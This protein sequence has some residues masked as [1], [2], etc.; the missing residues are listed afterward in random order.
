MNVLIKLSWGKKI[1]QNFWFLVTNRPILVTVVLLMIFAI[2]TLASAATPPSPSSSTASP[3]LPNTFEAGFEQT[4]KSV[5]NNKT[6]S[7]KGTIAYLYPGHI[8]FE[9][10]EPTSEKS[11]FISN[12]NQSWYYTPP[13]DEAEKGEV[14][15]QKSNR[16]FVVKFFDSIRS[17]LKNNSMYT[18]KKD[19][20]QQTP[21][22]TLTFS[23]KSAKE[24]GVVEAEIT[25]APN[26]TTSEFSKI[27][28][29]NIKYNDKKNVLLT[30]NDLHRDVPLTQENFIF[31]IPANTKVTEQN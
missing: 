19:E 10:T 24:I 18:V 13:F 9:V 25:F 30:L 12:S 28:S 6:R 16:L 8:R 20:S 11:L 23:K 31:S 1:K 29:I 17:G 14:I 15:I 27:K 26:S 7:G 21:I 2:K 3:F 5:I 22:Y 4:F